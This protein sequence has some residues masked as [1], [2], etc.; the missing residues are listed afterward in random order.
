MI[1]VTREGGIARLTL[2]DGKRAN[3]LGSDDWERLATIADELGA[4]DSLRVVVVSGSGRS[5]FSSGSDMREWIDATPEDVDSSFHLME[6]ACEA[7]ERLPVP[8][9]ASVRGV[10]AGAEVAAM[11]AAQPAAAIR[12]AKRSVEATLAPTRLAVS[13]QQATKSADYAG[14]RQQVE[15]FLRGPT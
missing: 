5:P 8:V 11:I 7:I 3:A 4:D 6:R 10:A 2:G 15:S 13:A 1:E 14:L 12:A 9:L